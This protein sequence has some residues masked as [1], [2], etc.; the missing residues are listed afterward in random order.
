MVSVFSLAR[1]LFVKEVHSE[2]SADIEIVPEDKD[3]AD[4]AF[5]HEQALKRIREQFSYPPKEKGIA[6]ESPELLVETH[7]TLITELR[8][9]VS[10]GPEFDKL[11]Y[12][13]IVRYARIVHLLPASESHHHRLMGGL[14][15]HGI[16]AGV[17]AY[18]LAE[19][20]EFT[21]NFASGEMRRNLEPK[22]R[23]AAFLAA[24]CHDLGKVIADIEVHNEDSTLR[25]NA[26]QESLA[27]WSERNHLK[28]YYV[29]WLPTR[30]NNRHIRFNASIA[31][32]VITPYAMA[33]LSEYGPEVQ[34]DLMASLSGQRDSVIAKISSK[35]DSLSV[36]KD[37]R[38]QKI[39]TGHM[40]VGISLAEH[41]VSKLSTL[42]RDKD[43]SARISDMEML[44]I[45]GDIYLQWPLIAEKIVSSL[46]VDGVSGIPS[47]PEVIADTLVD[48][49]LAEKSPVGRY[50][51]V[52]KPSKR[53]SRE[54]MMLKVTDAES[55]FP[56]SPPPQVVVEMEVHELPAKNRKVAG[57]LLTPEA[58]Q[59]LVAETEAAVEPLDVNTQ[60]EPVPVAPVEAVLEIDARSPV[61][62]AKSRSKPKPEFTD[63]E[64]PTLASTMQS[65]SKHGEAGQLLLAA[66]V[67]IKSNKLPYLAEQ[68]GSWI[69]RFDAITEGS[70]LDRTYIKDKFIATTNLVTP[71]LPGN[72]NSIVFTN[73]N[74]DLKYVRLHESIASEFIKKF[75]VAGVVK[76]AESDIPPPTPSAESVAPAKTE[77]PTVKAKKPK[78]KPQ[79]KPVT[80]PVE[81]APEADATTTPS[82]SEA[83]AAHSSYGEMGSMLLSAPIEQTNIEQADDHFLVPFDS[84][85]ALAGATE[86][87]VTAAKKKL[88][89][90]AKKIETINGIKYLRFE[91]ETN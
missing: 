48:N 29:S 85:L 21:S 59:E 4:E 68:N 31:P 39:M 11:Y 22:F 52:T 90:E 47:R 53:A 7:A 74:D 51:Y 57:A 25:W 20:V 55:L 56:S 36:N 71:S 79:P 50:Y 30:K 34:S 10:I 6:F 62:S 91:N 37:L 3:E 54:Y 89:C 49:G 75:K 70:G 82:D 86:V 73:P 88:L 38:T 64:N 61:S 35:A 46:Q 9:F 40:S 44:N 87:N 5:R 1:N 26:Y 17:Y 66:G 42:I 19:D 18:R 14:L 60:D 67:Y 81:S 77:P 45:N 83:P 12:D 33:Y 24:L 43:V 65:I 2:S 63:K 69:L 23:Y 72:P 27:D 32:L 8:Q 15:H 84:A 13:V 16:Q 76:E 78:P 58:A 28:R 41:L 80:T